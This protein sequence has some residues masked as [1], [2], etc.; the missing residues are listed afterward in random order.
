MKF[1]CDRCKTRYSIADERVRGKIL[2][3]RCKNCSTVITV[4]DGAQHAQPVQASPAQP[5]AGRPARATTGG[6]QRKRAGSKSGARRRPS[7]SS[8]ALQGAFEEALRRPESAAAVEL[9]AAPAVL[10]AE[11]YVSQDG[12]QL[13]PFTLARAQEWVADRGGDEELFCWSEGFDDWLPVEK[14][15]HFRGLRAGRPASGLLAMPPGMARRSSHGDEVEETL[16]HSTAGIVPAREETPVPLFAA[17]LAQVTAEAPSDEP[18]LT[19]ARR[20][21]SV[22]PALGPHGQGGRAPSGSPPGGGS[23]FGPAL[24]AA[25]PV[26]ANGSTNPGETGPDLSHDFEIGEASRVVRLPMLA[27]HAGNGDASPLGAPGLPGMGAATGGAGSFG[28]G[29][30]SHDQGDRAASV[31]PYIRGGSTVDLPR[32]EAMLP[33]RRRSSMV[34]PLGIGTAAVLGVVSVLLFVALSDDDDG[35]TVRRGEVGGK[36]GLAY[37]FED[38]DGDKKPDKQVEAVK[39]PARKA[40]R[41]T[42]SAGKSSASL[43]GTTPQGPT[44]VGSDEVDLS[45]GPAGELDPDDLFDVYNANKIGVTMCFNSA[46]KRDPLLSVRRADVVISVSPS[47]AVASVSIPSLSGTPL[48]TCLQKRIKSWRF[49]RASRVFNSRFPIIFQ[50]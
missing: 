21:G 18:P 5:G 50:T 35:A 45:G 3:I 30:G 32:S 1:H 12:E 2:K 29:T 37:T 33:R 27:R 26:G 48:G 9:A 10:E 31:L 4:K 16:L 38:K 41:R 20:N 49:P 7:T 19:S 34:L 22:A 24:A 39:A 11:W 43:T 23:L 47:G 17:T 28:R 13:G 25:G 42:S 44:A 46:L 6:A 40:P 36:G 15:S 14:V 8:G